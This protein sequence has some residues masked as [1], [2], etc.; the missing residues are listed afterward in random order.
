M[1][2]QT[3]VPVSE[4][5]GRPSL[6]HTV[7]AGWI[8]DPL[9]PVVHQGRYHLFFQ[10]VPGRTEWAPECRWGHAV[11]DDGLTWHPRPVVLEP[12]DGD[13][14][15]WSGCV[16]VPDD[17]PAR[18]FYTSVD[19]D[20]FRVGRI[21]VARAADDEWD[22]WVKGD[23]VAELPQGYPVVAFRD[24]YVFRDGDGWRM[25]VGA[26]RT[27]GTATA[28]SYSSPDLDTWRYDGEF[29][30]RSGDLTEPVWAGEVWECPQF[31]PLG[32]KHVLTV[33]AWRPTETFYEAYAVGA[34]A[35]GV[36][37]PE[38]WGRLTYG[39]GYYAGSA[40]CDR[41]GARGIIY[42]MPGVGG[43][44]AGWASANSIPHRL[45]LGADGRSVV[46]TPHPGVEAR[47]REPVAARDGCVRVPAAA[48]V[49]WSPVQDADLVLRDASGAEHLRLT[50]R[51]G[52]L[53]PVGP[54]QPQSVPL[55]GGH[56]RIVLDGPVV[57]VFAGGGALAH[58]VPE[59]V[60]SLGVEV[61]GG[62]SPGELVAYPLTV[63]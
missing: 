21:R 28:L 35:D 55:V 26:G 49:V 9:G 50:V 54:E 57:E 25:L 37:I 40:L 32:D 36:F 43:A 60:A 33:A 46:A 8:N 19:V 18:I 10:H 34:Y 3:S 13:G 39:R 24:P 23:V 61:D 15:C 2:A 44:D 27:D 62:A 41:D 56:V 1:T 16:V 6:H 4:A 12:G 52:T 53:R 38:R 31:F 58:V 14:G 7:A 5:V 45:E 20:D 48:D 59:P 22:T 42:W 47:R 11:S 51:G 17:G 63:G 29:L 30:A